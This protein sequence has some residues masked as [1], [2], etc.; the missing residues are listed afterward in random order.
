MS[1]TRAPV[2]HGATALTPDARA[3]I[4][5][6]SSAAEFAHN[7]RSAPG[8]GDG[9]ASVASGSSLDRMRFLQGA[10]GNR[11]VGD[12]LRARQTASRGR[13]LPPGVRSVLNSAGQALDPATRGL[14]ALRFGRDFGDVRVH[15]DAEAARSARALDARAYAVGRDVVFSEAAYAP[16]RREG[17]ELLAH[18]LAHVVQQARGGSAPEVSP[19]AAHER[20]A[21][22]AAKA[23]VGG[24]DRVTVSGATGVGIARAPSISRR[25]RRPSTSAIGRTVRLI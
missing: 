21:D 10:A 1:P 12:L 20:E 22:A 16:D 19:G 8:Q 15:T 14:M 4:E 2:D 23:A 11:A 7:D 3:R 25:P 6:R 5:T 18:E 13:E 24:A 9:P 17:S